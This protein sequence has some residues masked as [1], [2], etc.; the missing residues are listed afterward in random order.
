[1]TRIRDA[2]VESNPWWKED[3]ETDLHEREI[4]HQIGKYMDVPQI[5]AF[6][7]LRR[8][9]KTSLMLK[10]VEDTLKD[11]F[12]PKGV[13]Y[14]SFDEFR[15]TEPAEILKEY[16]YL[17]E[18][19]IKKDRSILLLDEVQ[20][21]IDW[22][23]RIKRIYDTH[24]KRLKII[25]S[26]S[27]SLF[28]KKKSKESLAGRI[29]EFRVGPLTFREFL[30]FKGVR[31]EPINIHEKELQKE[32]DEFTLTLGFPELVDVK[33]SNIIK[34]YITESVVE[35]IIYR[36]IPTIFKIDDP[37]VLEALLNIL[38]E[39]PG[40]IIKLESLANELNLSRQ[41]VSVYLTYLEESFML[42]KLYNYSKSRRKVERK[43][44]KYYPTIV[45][46]DLLIKDDILS[47]SMVFEWLIVNQLGAGY[48]WRDPYKHEVDIVIAD[49]AVT[50]V[51]IKYGKIDMD[52]IRTFIR[53]FN[54]DK[55]YIIT[56]DMERRLEINGK[57]IYAVPAYKYLLRGPDS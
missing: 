41:T 50:P 32:L 19:D 6:T 30:D 29:F 9:G 22:E 3:F 14:F 36:D 5:L 28:V 47:R 37:S 24:G 15:E 20:K 4:Y 55:G 53:K 48:F 46:P 10:I 52:G 43:L 40:Q 23:D 18:R 27:E 13:I 56:K 17:V 12:D 49:E 2:L 11:G 26:G 25:I 8:V 57:T 33:D 38:M 42:R 39:K 34:R 51:E 16:E 45:S 54:I 7:G 31:F 35:K 44:K 1:M 21:L